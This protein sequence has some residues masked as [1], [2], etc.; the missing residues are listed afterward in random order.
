MYG[1]YGVVALTGSSFLGVVGDRVASS[2]VALSWFSAFQNQDYV[3]DI[4]IPLPYRE[5]GVPYDTA[6]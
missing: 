5:R 2:E 1:V 3:F 4:S 6:M